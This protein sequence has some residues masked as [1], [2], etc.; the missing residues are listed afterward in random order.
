MKV[1]MQDRHF[2]SLYDNSKKA[3]GI[4]RVYYNFRSKSHILLCWPQEDG[5]ENSFDLFLK[6]P[7]PAIAS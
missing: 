4:A 1:K 3:T 7:E 2:F 5:R 6:A